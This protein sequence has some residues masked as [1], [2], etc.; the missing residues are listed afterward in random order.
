MILFTYDFPHKKTQDFIFYCAHYGYK[1]EAAIAA[2]KI[3][4]PIPDQK[5]KAGVNLNVGVIP[6]SELCARLKI[7]YLVSPHNST[8]TI[9]HLNL[10]K[11]EL[12]LIAGARILSKEVIDCFSKGII[13]FHP[14]PIPEARGLDTAQWIVYDDLPLAVTSHFIDTRVD[15]G[16]IIKRLDIE[17]DSNDSLQDIGVKLYLG[18]L[19]IFRE[20]FTRVNSGA[21]LPRVPTNAKASYKYFPPELEET[22]MR[23]LNDT[24]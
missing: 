16:H 2:P 23:R 13:N 4:L 22:M 21:P 9:K 20:T 11:P 10:L 7:P 1:I 17:K 24:N 14:G 12:G 6:T 19:Q 3:K 15:G 5:Y 18:Q 8:G